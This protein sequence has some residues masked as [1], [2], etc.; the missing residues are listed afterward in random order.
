MSGQ[1]QGAYFK[2]CID[3]STLDTNSL[4][5]HAYKSTL[6]ATYQ[7]IDDGARAMRGTRSHY[8]DRF[9]QGLVDV[10]GQILLSP[11]PTELDYLLPWILGANESSDSFATA[12]LLQSRN[13][14][15]HVDLN[16]MH[17][18]N[19]VYVD[20][21]VFFS[22]YDK[23]LMLLLDLVGTSETIPTN[24]GSFP[25][26]TFD[27]GTPYAFHEGVLTVQGGA[28]LF[29]EFSLVI[30]NH[31]LRSFNNSRT[32]TSIRAT[33]R[34]V[35]LAASSP[36]TDD[37]LDLF[38]TPVSSIAGSSGTLVFSDGTDSCTFSFA[39]LKPYAVGPEVQGKTEI[40]L[41]LRYRAARTSGT[42]E[43]V[44]TSTSS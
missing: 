33:D 41:P 36:Y 8:Q 17:Q 35:W 15:V 16:G 32:A 3:E 22:S 38:E 44:V 29:D 37:E 28:E 14:G 2:L 21:A 31:V 13:V 30:D 25:A 19:T 10:S 18:F 20:K 11:T 40:R 1:A 12:E 34:T 42:A 27:D 26:L 6:K 23:Y 5:L 7:V 43:I 4:P 39:N 24:A 9:K